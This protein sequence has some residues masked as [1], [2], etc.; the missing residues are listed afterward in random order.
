MA[1]GTG[2]V[3]VENARWKPTPTVTLDNA[4]IIDGTVTLGGSNDITLA[5]TSVAPAP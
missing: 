5:A 4:V 3:T 2:T 1:L